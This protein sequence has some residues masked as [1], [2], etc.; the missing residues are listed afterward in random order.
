MAATEQQGGPP[1]QLPS[2]RL[3]PD[4]SYRAAAWP[5]LL[6]SLEICDP[7]DRHA[8]HEVAH[9][10]QLVTHG[11]AIS[12][13]GWCGCYLSSPELDNGIVTSACIPQLGVHNQNMNWLEHGHRTLNGIDNKYA[14]YGT[15]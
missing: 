7:V 14:H 11:A 10:A 6:P 15:R 2:S 13:G 1:W 4:G 8:T 12:N 9:F 3:P 5:L